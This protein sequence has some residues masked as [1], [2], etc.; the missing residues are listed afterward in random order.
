MHATI[1]QVLHNIR[2]CSFPHFLEQS[3]EREDKYAR[4]SCK[5]NLLIAYRGISVEQQS[6]DPPRGGRRRRK[7]LRCSPHGVSV[8]KVALNFDKQW[9]S[10]HRLKGVRPDR[11]VDP[12]V[13]DG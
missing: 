11:Q 7:L 1:P 10:H 3:G 9:I 4:R 2:K 8:T 12:P 13:R 5:P 6:P